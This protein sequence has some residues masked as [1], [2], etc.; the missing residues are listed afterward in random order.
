MDQSLLSSRAVIG[1]YFARLE[2][3]PGLSWVNAISNLFNSDQASE[4]Y[5]FLGLPPLMREWIGGRQAKGLSSNALTITNKHYE[6]TLEVA[7]RDL[8]R[9]KTGQLQV[10]IDEFAD[11]GITHWAS[12]LSELIANGET[13]LCYDGQYFF[14][15]DHPIA[16]AVQSNRIQVDISALPATIHGVPGSPS[17][18]EMQQSILAGISTMLALKDDRGEP[19]NENARSF[20]VMVP[21]NMW[22]VALAA[23]TAMTTL[24][25]QNN[26]NPNQIPDMQ[27]KVELNARLAPSAKFSVWRNDSPVKALIRQSEQDSQLKAKAEESEYAFDNDAY[28]FGIDSW[29]NVGYGYW[30]RAVLVEMI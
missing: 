2:S 17:V 9:D 20:T 26:V 15:V 19:L 25:L 28:Q 16:G 14:D 5:A 13:T 12:M 27:I 22:M 29:R 24:S 6:A 21:S 23:T 11:A 3:N 8:R 7:V 10:R 18:E 4:Q 30:Q 1:M